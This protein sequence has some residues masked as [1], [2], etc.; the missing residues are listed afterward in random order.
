MR[1]DHR[2]QEQRFELKYLI[3]ERITLAL[4]DFISGFLEPDEYGVAQ[5]NLA[6]PVY[7]LYL[8]SDDLKTYQ[9]TINGTRNRFKLRLRFYDDRPESPVFFEVKRRMNNCILKQRGPVRRD[10]VEAL[11]AGHLPEAGHLMGAAQDGFVA[12]QRFCLLMN[13]LRA[14]PKAHNHYWREAWVSPH[15]NAVRVTIDRHIC[16]EPCFSTRLAAQMRRPTLVFGKA[17]VLEL[18]F[19]D[20]FPN[21]FRDLVRR[22]NL[23]QFAAAKYAEGI[24]VLGEHRFHDGD[25]RCGAARLVVEPAALDP[26]GLLPLT[27]P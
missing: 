20:R 25:R 14:R 21:W 1:Q 7:S 5:A 2:L 17:D 19:T 23:M 22:F 11:L 12:L 16:I 24:T 10:A 9:A 3:P 26:G 4:R 13:Q 6:Y 8:D 15:D 27:R 18:K